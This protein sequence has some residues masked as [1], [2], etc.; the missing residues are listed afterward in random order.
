MKRL[1]SV[2][3]SVVMVILLAGCGK[4]EEPASINVDGRILRYIEQDLTVSVDNSSVVGIWGVAYSTNYYPDKNSME[5]YLD[6]SKLG[7]LDKVEFFADGSFS[8]VSGEGTWHHNKGNEFEYVYSDMS[9]TTF[10]IYYDQENDVLVDRLNISDF[11]A[12]TYYIR[13]E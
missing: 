13:E 5:M 7:D 2:F 9:D 11:V 6:F 8:D 10:K 4:K 1:F 12:L 3:V